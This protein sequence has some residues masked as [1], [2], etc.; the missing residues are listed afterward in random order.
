MD[1]QILEKYAL[2]QNLSDFKIN[3]PSELGGGEIFGHKIIFAANSK[4]FD[5]IF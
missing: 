4:K 2:S 3:I 1:F 5:D